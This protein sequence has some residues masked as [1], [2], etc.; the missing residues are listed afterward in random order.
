MVRAGVQG[1]A[2]YIGYLLGAHGK[3]PGVGVSKG[4]FKTR[5]MD[6]DSRNLFKVD[7]AKGGCPIKA[8]LWVLT[9]AK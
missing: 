7:Q 3:V 6:P 5:I 9:H 4:G 2:D 8:V 1:H